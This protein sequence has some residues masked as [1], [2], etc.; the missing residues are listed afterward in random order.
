MPSGETVASIYGYLGQLVIG[1]S[2][3]VRYATQSSSGGISL[4]AL[5]ATTASGAT[6]TPTST[7]QPVQALYGYGRWVWFGWTNYDG[8]STGLGRIDLET[9]V[10]A[11]VLPSYASDL[12]ATAQGAVTGVAVLGG[13][14]AFCVSGQGVYVQSTSLVASG[15]IQ[16]GYVLYDL[17][18]SKIAALIDVETPGPI[19]HG[20]Y[21]VALATNGGTFNTVG[22]HNVGD[23]EPV[24]YTTAGAN[25]ERFEVLLTL[26]RDGSTTTAG[27]TITRWTLRAYPA[28]RR[29]VTW[30][31]PLTFD[32]RIIDNS[33]GTEGF[34]P[35]VELQALEQMAADGEPVTYQEA[36]QSYSVFVQ[37]VQFLPDELT[38]DKHYFNGLCLVTLESVP[39]PN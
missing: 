8:T 22:T 16:S 32:E 12:M 28:P 18:D 19:T 29:P 2:L 31:L 1:T 39:V 30:Q 23:A 20:S 24:T 6:W 34:D 25:G 27:P 9:F 10:V 26:N 7:T 14:V 3:G 36:D 11:G 4:G 13:T 38:T 5:I 15:T 21:S 37:D 17:A 35:L 33:M